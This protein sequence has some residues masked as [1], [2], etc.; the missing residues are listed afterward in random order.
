MADMSLPW[1][2]VS[3]IILAVI[4]ILLIIAKKENKQQPASRLTLLAMGF[5]VL[6]IVFGSDRL[7]GYSF[8]GI[9]VIIAVFDLVKN[10]MKQ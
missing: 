6:G 2:A 3:L 4:G 5:I 7:I 9:G 1:I 8:L 10:K